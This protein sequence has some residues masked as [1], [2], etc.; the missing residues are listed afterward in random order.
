MPTEPQAPDAPAPG[1]GPGAVQSDAPEPSTDGTAE[2]RGNQSPR[3]SIVVGGAAVIGLGIG[4]FL[5][6]YIGMR[7]DLA[8]SVTEGLGAAL[9]LLVAI[10]VIGAVVSARGAHHD[11][12]G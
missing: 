8:D 9:G 10:S 1:T 11:R 2:H 6:S 5:I 7:D 4:W 12:D 3:W